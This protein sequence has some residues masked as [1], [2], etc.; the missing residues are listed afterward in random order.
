MRVIPSPSTGQGKQTA[1]T[2][3][4]VSPCEQG[5]II[6][7]HFFTRSMT[8][9]QE[10]LRYKSTTPLPIL[11]QWVDVLVYVLLRPDVTYILLRYQYVVASHLD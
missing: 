5:D 3:R 1:V 6:G 11:K 2:P 9:L 7:E 10:N 4:R 8:S